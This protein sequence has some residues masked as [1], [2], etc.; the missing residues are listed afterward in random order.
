MLE[1]NPK[2]LTGHRFLGFPKPEQV[3]FLF[4]QWPIIDGLPALKHVVCSV[5]FSTGQAIKINLNQGQP[6]TVVRVG[7]GGNLVDVT[8]GQAHFVIV[9]LKTRNQ[10]D[11]TTIEYHYLARRLDEQL[12]FDPNG[13]LISFTLC[14][15]CNPGRFGHFNLDQHK[16]YILGVLVP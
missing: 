1:F 10:S 3:T 4:A 9:G 16:I 12:R 13:E 6:I 8:R 2:D 5:V 14:A 7:A 15:D 11:L